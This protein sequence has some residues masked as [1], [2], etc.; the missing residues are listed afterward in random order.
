MS[1]EL[2]QAR[3]IAERADSPIVQ[4]SIRHRGCSIRLNG[5][6]RRLDVSDRLLQRGLGGRGLGLRTLQCGR[7]LTCGSV[8]VPRIQFDDVITFVHRLVIHYVDR[9]DA[10]GR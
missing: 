3:L 1:N 7:L 10:P 9:L 2:D 5:R 4:G 6:L 8:E